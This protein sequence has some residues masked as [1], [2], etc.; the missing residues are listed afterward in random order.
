[1]R[2]ICQ[3]DTE[4][5]FHH[6]HMLDILH[7]R[8]RTRS[9]FKQPTSRTCFQACKTVRPCT[10]P[11]RQPSSSNTKKIASAASSATATSPL[12]L[13]SPARSPRRRASP[14]STPTAPRRCAGAAGSGRRTRTAKRTRAAGTAADGPPRSRAG[15]TATELRFGGAF[16][17]RTR[18]GPGPDPT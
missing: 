15:C 14:G 9:I 1:M 11:L 12:C 16:C 5:Q 4:V 3:C 7:G 6:T 13:F 17:P 2:Y 10:W 8:R 18:P